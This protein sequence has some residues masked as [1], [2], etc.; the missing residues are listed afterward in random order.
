MVI[1]SPG[2]MSRSASIA[3]RVKP[4]KVRALAMDHN[5]RTGEVRALL[6]AVC[7]RI[8]VGWQ[9]KDDP[10]VLLRLA[11]LLLDPPSRA[12]WLADGAVHPG[13]EDDSDELEEWLEGRRLL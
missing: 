13:W 10:L 8:V 12:A 11:L 1:S 5:H 2:S 6:C 9:A 7:N 3:R 4:G